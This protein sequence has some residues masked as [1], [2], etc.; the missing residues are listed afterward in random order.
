MGGGPS[1]T[2]AMKDIS[3]GFGSSL[4]LTETAQAIKVTEYAGQGKLKKKLQKGASQYGINHS[5]MHKPVERS[6]SQ[7]SFVNKLSIQTNLEDM[8][9]QERRKL[10][11]KSQ[12]SK[13]LM[14]LNYA[15]KRERLNFSKKMEKRQ[16]T[17]EVN[18]SKQRK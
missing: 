18:L 1:K 16:Q 11:A 3:G 4:F 13:E 5:S 14:L 15:N 7:L 9:A 2:P 8:I 17:A 10:F 12:K 6:P